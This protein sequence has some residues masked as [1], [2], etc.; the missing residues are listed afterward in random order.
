MIDYEVK[1]DL[2]GLPF[3]DDNDDLGEGFCLT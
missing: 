2:Q 1:R 3:M